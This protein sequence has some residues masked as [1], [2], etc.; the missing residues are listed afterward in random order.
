[1]MNNRIICILIL[2]ISFSATAMSQKTEKPDSKFAIWFGVRNFDQPPLNS[3]DNIDFFDYYLIEDWDKTNYKAIYE[4]LGFSYYKKWNELIET[5]LRFT[6]DPGF[7]PNTFYLRGTYYPKPY[8]GLALSYYVYPQLLNNYDEYF[9]KSLIYRNM[10]SQIITEQYPQWNLHDHTV[11]I[12]AVSPLNLGSLHLK[13]GVHAGLMFIS[14]FKTSI[15]LRDKNSYYKTMLNYRFTPS[16]TV[17]INPDASLE[18]DILEF[19]GKAIGFQ[20]QTS[21][22]WAKRSINYKITQNEWTMESSSTE[23]VKGVQ[24]AFEKFE[25]DGGLFYKW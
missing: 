4:Y 14:P 5:D 1:M 19:N 3:S 13:L 9:Q 2:G 7:T 11:S 20:F 25:F 24:H 22:L 6:V 10:Y 23:N 8:L 12:G 16:T 18:I 21:W 17:F 15:F